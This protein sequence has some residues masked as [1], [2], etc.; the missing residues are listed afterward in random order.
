[1]LDWLSVRT[2]SIVWIW[3]YSSLFTL[4]WGWS[5]FTRPAG[6]PA[7]FFR[8]AGRSRPASRPVTGRRPAGRPSRAWSRAEIRAG[9]PHFLISQ[10]L[11]A[12][13]ACQKSVS[14]RSTLTYYWLQWSNWR[15]PAYLIADLQKLAYNFYLGFMSFN[16]MCCWFGW[17]A[18]LKCG[19]DQWPRHCIWPKSLLNWRPYYD[20]TVKLTFQQYL[21]MQTSHNVYNGLFGMLSSMDVSVWTM[22]RLCGWVWPWHVSGTSPEGRPIMTQWSNCHSRSSAA[23]KSCL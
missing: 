19:W 20:P 3:L 17:F 15:I 4:F 8:P 9:R 13:R 10:A 5:H 1:M 6:R 14:R 11:P 12:G 7:G 18:G 16:E 23:A 21:P 2:I 22:Y